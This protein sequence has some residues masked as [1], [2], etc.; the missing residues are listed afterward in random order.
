MNIFGEDDFGEDTVGILEDHHVPLVRT[1]HNDT[2]DMLES[3]LRGV[4]PEI[5]ALWAGGETGRPAST[6]DR[7]RR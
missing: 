5:V 4:L 6:Q 1:V 2:N 7:G 3:E